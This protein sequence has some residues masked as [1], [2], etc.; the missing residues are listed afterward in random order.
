MGVPLKKVIWKLLSASRLG[1]GLAALLL[2]NTGLFSPGKLIYPRTFLGWGFWEMAAPSLCSAVK[3]DSDAELATH[4]S[5]IRKL[6][7]HESHKG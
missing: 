2:E 5:I 3:G 6:P 4:T 1:P 7:F